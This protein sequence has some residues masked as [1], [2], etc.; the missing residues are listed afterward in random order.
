MRALRE[1]DPD[2]MSFGV[3]RLPEIHFAVARRYRGSEVSGFTASK[4]VVY[5]HGPNAEF[6]DVPSQVTAGWY[7]ERGDGKQPYGRPDNSTD[8]DWPYLVSALSEPSFQSALQDLMARHGLRWATTLGPVHA[9]AR[10]DRSGREWQHR[11][12]RRVRSRRREW[13]A[14]DRRCD[15][16]CP[17]DQ[18]IDLHIVRT[19]PKALA[20]DSG[21]PFAL[22]ELAPLL[23]DIARVYLQTIGPG[24]RS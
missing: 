8:W 21:Q 19:W 11:R 14:R 5:A 18:W 9:R 4:L 7:I 3:E 6:P 23:T 20:I 2:F 17:G 13:L 22:R 12:P 16:G 24:W 1:L 10:L 15:R